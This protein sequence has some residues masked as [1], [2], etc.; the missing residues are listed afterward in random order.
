MS[1]SQGAVLREA[2]RP[3][4]ARPTNQAR[5]LA[6]GFRPHAGQ[7]ARDVVAGVRQSVPEYGRLL[8]GVFGTLVTAAAQAAI[9]RCVDALVEPERPREDWAPVFRKLGKLEWDE[10]RSPDALQAAYRVGGQVAWRHILDYARSHQASNDILRW[11][12]DAI[13]AQ[14]GQASTLSAEGYAGAQTS[15]S[16]ELR[17]KRKLLLRHLLAERPV[18]ERTLADSARAAHW[19]V[20][21]TVTVVALACPAGQDLPEPADPGDTVLVDLDTEEPCLIMATAELA[22]LPDVLHGWHAAIGPAVPVANAR[23][24]LRVARRALD[25]ADRGLIPA[26]PVIDCAAHRV[27]LTLFANELLITAL[28]DRHLAPLRG[29]PERQQGQILATLNEWLATRGH[30]MEIAS[31]LGVHPQTVRTRVHR[32]KELFGDGLDDPQIR[33][34]LELAARAKQLLASGG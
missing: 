30:V 14:V 17:L 8:D 18:N 9:L 23:E 32:L 26:S 29:L 12:A 15:A 21:G 4:E 1:P 22:T 19:P 3:A 7:L 24:S 2:P 16:G 5:E 13:S 10:G 11:C 34:E 6:R 28:I 31:R 25:L 27:P 33:F 20:P